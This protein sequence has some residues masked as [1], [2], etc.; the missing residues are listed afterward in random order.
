MSEFVIQPIARGDVDQLFVLADALGPGMTTLPADRDALA[1]KIESSIQSFERPGPSGQYVLAARAPESNAILGV[2][3]V[4]ADVGRPL[5]FFSFRVSELI[6][7]SRSN[8]LTLRSDLLM[9]VNDYTGLTEVGSLAVHP[10]ARSKGLGRSLAKSRYLL[11]AAAPHL[12]GERIIAEMRGWQDE[13]GESPF[14]KAVGQRFFDVDFDFADKQSAV[15]GAAYFADLLPRHPIYAALLPEEARTVIGRPHRASAPAMV[16]LLEE[17]F[18][19]ENMVDIFDAGP[20]VVAA[21]DSIGAVRRAERMSF[22][23]AEPLWNDDEA[24][25]ANPDLSA[26]CVVAAR[27]AARQRLMAVGSDAEI[28]VSR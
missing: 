18:R 11:I 21:R 9:V 13:R 2:A 17:G 12:F 6:Q 26:F 1:A 23:A 16:M 3:A 27:G 10:A 22:A 7:H 19:Y 4:Y 28:L 24:L 20:Q 14:W 5:G 8:D 15:L 25:F